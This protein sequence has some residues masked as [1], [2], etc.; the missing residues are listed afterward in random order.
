MDVA[1]AADFT[2]L[3]PLLT[4]YVIPGLYQLEQ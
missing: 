3:A 1:A 2:D 4:D